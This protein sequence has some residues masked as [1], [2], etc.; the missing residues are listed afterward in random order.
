MRKRLGGVAEEKL[1]L[2]AGD[3]HVAQTALFL[4]ALFVLQ[5]SAGGKYAFFQSG[6]EYD[7][8][9]QP[10]GAVYGHQRDDLAPKLRTVQIAYQ[11]YV[12]QIIFQR[13][14]LGALF[15]FADRTQELFDVFQT[16]FA[17]VGQVALI[18]RLEP[19]RAR[20]N[21]FIRSPNSLTHLRGRAESVSGTS[22]RAL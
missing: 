7:G 5:A 22:I 6:D 2:R 19:S 21:S 9:F 14:G 12:F 3:G 17:F 13:G 18:L 16:V 4:H 15:V 11:R 20:T 1:L 8:E 10:L